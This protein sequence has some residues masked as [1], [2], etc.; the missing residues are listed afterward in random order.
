MIGRDNYDL[1]APR[2]IHQGHPNTAR[3]IQTKLGWTASGRTDLP[4]K[5]TCQS[6]IVKSESRECCKL[7]EI[8]YNGVLN[9]YKL[10]NLSS[11]K[12]V[13]KSESNK[14]ASEISESTLGFK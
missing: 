6:Q 2:Q 12:D 8:L 14:R 5:V 9:W 4:S 11:N 7:D 13:I 3:A 10:E 1:V